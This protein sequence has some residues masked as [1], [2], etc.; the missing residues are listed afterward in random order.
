MKTNRVPRLPRPT[1]AQE[2]IGFLDWAQL[3]QLDGEP[4]ALRVVKIPNERGRAGVHVAVMAKLGMRKGFPDYQLLLPV[5]GFHGLFI[6]AKRAKQGRAAGDQL[7]WQSHLRGWGYA[8]EICEGALEMI[9]ATRAYLAPLC[10]DWHPSDRVQATGRFVDRT[11]IEGVPAW[12][13]GDATTG[14]AA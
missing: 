4:L 13:L 11:R 10:L 3:A 5:G 9:A 7:L 6:E 8:A 2:C 1:E 14:C 12:K